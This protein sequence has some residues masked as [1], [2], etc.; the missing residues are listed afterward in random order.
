MSNEVAIRVE[1]LSKAYRIG[2]QE[3]R[4][5][6]LAAAFASFVRSPFENYRNL[7]KLSR[8]ND[9]TPSS[10]LSPPSSRKPSS[11]AS[12]A[13][14][15][16]PSSD[17][18]S[19][20]LRSPS[21]D[22]SQSDV[23]WA[24]KNVSFEVKPG[25]VVGI[26]GRNGAGKSTLLKILARI[27]EP[28]NGCATIYGRV[29]SLLE[30]GTGFHPDLTG[31]EN[32]FLNG[33]ILGMRKREIEARF[34]EIVQFSEVEKFIDT[35]VKRYSSGMRVRL[36]FAVAA[37]LEPE[38]LIVDEVLAVG[39]AAFQKKCLGKMQDVAGKGRTVLFVSHNMSAILDLCTRSI[40][41]DHGSVLF[42]GRPAEG[43]EK[44][45]DS[46][47]AKDDEEGTT[48][49]SSLLTGVQI[50]ESINGKVSSG[51]PF[52]V[53]VCVGEPLPAGSWLFL[54]MEDFTGRTVFHKRI[55]ASEINMPVSGGPW[56]LV[57]SVPELWLTG[58][59]YSIYFKVLFAGLADNSQ[60]RTSERV[61]LEVNG[62]LENSGKAILNPTVTWS[63]I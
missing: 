6:T 32:I 17:T 36:A 48:D 37:Y 16:P 4:H 63:V 60:R 34:D 14:L 25:E 52:E 26:I 20:I 49:S 21:S 57:V 7:R 19:S 13:V 43:V 1:G 23:I 55:S 42:A 45:I 8:F 11:E 15:R 18:P 28:T 12:S 61:L 3:Q 54:I 29:G 9:V 35:P 56:R 38:I 59:V 39:D 44:Y 27:T 50:N 58:G 47:S 40:V 33:T 10:V 22:T 5:E 30:I 62:E 24:L 2:L 46:V 31:R 53:S 51:E 41:L